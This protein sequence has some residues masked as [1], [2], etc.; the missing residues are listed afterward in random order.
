MSDN[1]EHTPFDQQPKPED[2][3][4]THEGAPAEAEPAA[5]S[6]AASELSAEPAESDIADAPE[7]LAEPV[8]AE[9]TPVESTS[10]APTVEPVALTGPEPAQ[11]A[12]SF[13]TADVE[14]IAANVAAVEAASVASI[15][16]D[17]QPE[18]GARP[19]PAL[20]D[21]L[22]PVQSAPAP[23]YAAQPGPV[24][25]TAPVAPEPKGNRSVGILIAVLA[26]VVFAALDAA[27]AYLILLSNQGESTALTTLESYLRS[28]SF[29]L[30]AVVF[31]LAFVALIAIVNRAGWWAHVLGSIFVAAFVYAAF[32]GAALL[33]I[34]VWELTG[35]EFT[36]YLHQFIQSDI[37]YVWV[38]FVSVFV[39]FEVVIWFGLWISRRGAAVKRR[40]AQ[41]RAAYDEQFPNPRVVA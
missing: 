12:P 13:A 7:P 1:D 9:P 35:D 25:V 20:P 24:F 4:Q 32:F 15:E 40:N 27:A 8:P 41:A 39:A 11:E 19:A 30:P 17:A 22:V 23:A 34:K 28:Y 16:A 14:R 36:K 31:F 2:A 33:Q 3:A 29:W 5:G 6:E 37:P 18:T 38:A 26:T 21:P 10:A